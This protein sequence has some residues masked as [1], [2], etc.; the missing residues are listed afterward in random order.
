MTDPLQRY[1]SRMLKVLE[2]IER[3]LG[4]RLD[5]DALSSVAAFSKYHFHRQFAATF[6]LPASRYVQLARMKQASFRL[7]DR[8]GRVTD[9]AM[10]AGYGA[11]DAFARAF[12]Q[13]FGQ[14][15]SAFRDSPDWETWLAVLATFNQARNTFMQT[16]QTRADVTIRN[17]ADIPV[18]IMEHH[19]APSTIGATIRHFIDWRRSAGLRPDTSATFNIF[20]S[21]PRTTPPENYRLALCAGLGRSIETEGQ[22][23]TTG[24]IPGGRCAVL[25]IVGGADDLESAAAWLYREWLPASGEEPRDFPLYCQR[26][27]FFPDVPENETVTELFLPLE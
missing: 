3:N 26:L 4:E 10:E 2:H 14:R 11:P 15:P 22:P 20:H 27:S 21:D 13:Q 18:A 1:R 25:R 5:L 24:I 7:A 19:G 17:V 23:V 12:R 6:G 8:S 16:I 9:I